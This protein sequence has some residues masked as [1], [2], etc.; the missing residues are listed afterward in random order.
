VLIFIPLPAVKCV[1]SCWCNATVLPYLTY[2]IPTTS[3]LCLVSSLK[4]VI[5]EPT[6]YKFTFQVPTVMPIFCCLGRSWKV[7]V[8]VWGS[9]NCFATSLFL[10]WGVVRPMPNPQPPLIF[11]QQLLIQYIHSYTP[12]H[13]VYTYSE[14][15]SL[16]WRV[17]VIEQEMS[18]YVKHLLAKH[19]RWLS[20]GTVKKPWTAVPCLSGTNDLHRENI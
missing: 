13:A 18:N 20:K 2:C 8:Q 9:V 15:E 5:R 16:L 19:F 14:R 1:Y 6:L 4:S 12:V 3:N 11:C 17:V 10:W 7:C